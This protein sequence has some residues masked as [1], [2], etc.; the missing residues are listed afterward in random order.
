MRAVTLIIHGTTNLQP[1]NLISVS[2]V[3]PALEG[4]Y[5]ITNLTEK[6]TPTEF[7][8]IIEGKLLK[9]KRLVRGGTD[10]FI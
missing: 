1:F 4:I 6:I 2:G 10:V 3:L 5:I 8:T 9:R 7:Q